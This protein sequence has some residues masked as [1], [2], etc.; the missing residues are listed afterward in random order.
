M[1]RTVRN[2]S[3][4]GGRDGA[5]VEKYL[6]QDDTYTGYVGETIWNHQA[7]KRNKKAVNKHNRALRNMI[8]DIEFSTCEV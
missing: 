5:K 7:K 4:D 2:Y 6:R 3:Y 1:A 8:N